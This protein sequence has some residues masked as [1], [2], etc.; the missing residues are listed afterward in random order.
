M[1]TAAMKARLHL[2][3]MSDANW[4][5]GEQIETTYADWHQVSGDVAASTFGATF[6][7][8][9]N[10]T[11]AISDVPRKSLEM[12]RIFNW[13]VDVDEPAGESGPYMVETRTI[14]P[15]SM[16]SD[17]RAM[18]NRVLLE[19][20][21]DDS[22]DSDTLLLMVGQEIVDYWGF[23]SE[24][25]TSYPSLAAAMKSYPIPASALW[26]ARE[27]DR[28]YSWGASCKHVEGTCVFPRANHAAVLAKAIIAEL[29]TFA[30]VDTMARLHELHNHL[31]NVIHRI[32]RAGDEVPEWYGNGVPRSEWADLP[33]F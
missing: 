12:V 7:R 4:R 1:A 24:P 20:E 18:F 5:W 25:Y 27:Y 15:W 8:V 16:T 14:E 32:D 28:Q 11:R 29:N 30:G 17:V 23:E 6:A 13:E 19:R 2:A 33:T 9:C 31:A 10:E 22:I 21:L 26:D 3:T